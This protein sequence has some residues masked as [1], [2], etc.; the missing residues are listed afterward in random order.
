MKPRVSQ[1][2]LHRRHLPARREVTA[3]LRASSTGPR[4]QHSAGIN[5]DPPENRLTSPICKLRN[6]RRASSFRHGD[7]QLARGF[8]GKMS[9]LAEVK[10]NRLAAPRTGYVVLAAR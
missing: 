4:R 7:V 9:V 3:P 6:R 1:S 8:S 10:L 2:G 5:R